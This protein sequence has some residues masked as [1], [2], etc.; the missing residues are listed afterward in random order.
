MVWM[1]LGDIMEASRLLIVCS[2]LHII[3]AANVDLFY[4]YGIALDQNL[5][6]IDGDDIASEEYELKNPIVFYSER[7]NSVWVSFI[8]YELFHLF[9]VCASS[10]S[11]EMALGWYNIVTS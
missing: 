3:Y 8:G 4:P 2:F 9:T 5:N 1:M 7:K 11:S 10:A 6:V